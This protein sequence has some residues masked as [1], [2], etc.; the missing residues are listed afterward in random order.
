MKE[1]TGYDIVNDTKSTLW[2]L[3]AKTGPEYGQGFVIAKCNTMT[4]GIVAAEAL[5]EMYG[6]PVDPETIMNHFNRELLSE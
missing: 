2:Q 3:V 1:I 4:D 5:E 6:L